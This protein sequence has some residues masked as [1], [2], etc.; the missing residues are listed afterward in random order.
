VLQSARAGLALRFDHASS[1]LSHCT[2]T[3]NEEI[4]KERAF[5]YVYAAPFAAF[6]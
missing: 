1:L 6:T 2:K 5:S 4:D 3:L